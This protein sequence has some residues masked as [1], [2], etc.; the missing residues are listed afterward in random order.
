MALITMDAGFALIRSSLS[1]VAFLEWFLNHSSHSIV[2]QDTFDNLVKGHSNAFWCKSSSTCNP[3]SPGSCAIAAL[4]TIF[5]GGNCHRTTLDGGLCSDRRLYVHSM[6]GTGRS[7]K[8][9]SL[10][11]LGLWF[12]EDSS[13]NKI[14]ASAG[15]HQ[16]LMNC[17]GITA[18]STVF[19]DH[20]MLKQF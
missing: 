17:H 19:Y 11:T 20:I 18:W 9:W 1:S 14:N 13:G 5:H 4:P 6:C 10:R 16:E 8:E 3:R 15:Y 2:S 12:L 7:W